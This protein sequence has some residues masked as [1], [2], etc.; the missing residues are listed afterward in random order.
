AATRAVAAGGKPMEMV[1]RDVK[2]ENVLVSR[3]GEIK[4]TDFGIA[5]ANVRAAK[6]QIGMVKGTAAYMAPEQRI[7]QP[8]DR[9]ADVYGVGAI[10]YELLTG[11]ESNLDVDR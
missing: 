5:K 10:A 6:T 11:Q 9:R 8:V 3:V 4:V 1:H 7:G 2:A